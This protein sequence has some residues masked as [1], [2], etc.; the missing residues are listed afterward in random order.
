MQKNKLAKLQNTLTKYLDEMLDSSFDGLV[1]SDAEANVIKTNKAYLELSGLNSEEIVGHNLKDLIDEGTLKGAV[2]FEVT[3][4]H[5][6]TTM[7]HKYPRTGKIAMVTGNPV[8]DKQGALLY[9]IANFRDITRLSKLSRELGYPSISDIPKDTVFLKSELADLPHFGILVRNKKMKECLELA[10][11]VAKFDSHVLILGESGV[12]KTKLAEIIHGAS[13]RSK[14][15]F[16]SINCGSIPENLLE[17]EL[18]GYVKGAFT[19]ASV[20]GK[21]GLFEA[22]SGGT[23]V[24]DEIGDLSLNLQVKLLQAI[25][26]KH[27]FKIGSTTPIDID[28]RIIATTNQNLRN[29]VSKNEFRKDLYFRL[30]VI[31]VVIPPLRERQDEIPLF[32][33]YFFDQF[34]RQY[35]THKFPSPEVIE[36]LSQYEFPGNVRELR[37][38]IERLAIM[39]RSDYVSSEHL[40]YI[41]FESEQ[42]LKVFE[43][44]KNST[45]QNLLDRF[46]KTI[47]SKVLEQEYSHKETS[48]RLGISSATLWRK[49]NKYGLSKKKMVEHIYGA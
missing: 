34:N 11:R 29:M 42:N 24:L 5:V 28:A 35:G 20:K 10:V 33:K 14:H 46:E 9:V 17:S 41:P 18:F 13:C 45:L 49:M 32:S 43:L 40:K 3:K 16:I 23:I 47:I 12:G 19:G 15:P 39:S 30:S 44:K 25:E 8:F 21:T 7:M 37:N 6:P 38:L 26:E 2:V 27:I 36:R 4:T 22:A 48:K 1:I 31:P